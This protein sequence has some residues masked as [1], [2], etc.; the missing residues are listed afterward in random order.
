MK[1]TIEKNIN[2][3]VIIIYGIIALICVSSVYYMYQMREQFAKQKQSLHHIN[4]QFS[5]T[6]AIIFEIQEAQNAA[7]LLK[8]QNKKRVPKTSTISTKQLATLKNL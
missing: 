2:A 4:Q 5:L 1:S 6:N 7:H 3:S 8:F